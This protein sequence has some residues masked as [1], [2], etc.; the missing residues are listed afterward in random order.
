MEAAFL[1]AMFHDMGYP[2]QYISHL[3]NNL[4]L[5]GFQSDS[6]SSEAA[7]LVSTFGNRLLYSPL[8]GY[9]ALGRNV[10]ANFHQRLIDITDR[11]LR[12]THG[13][14]GAIGFL[15]LND[16][17][18]DYP[19]D[20]THPIRQFCVEW[21][22]MAI[23]MHDM[24]KIYWGDDTKALPDNSHMRLRFETDPLS[25]VVT[26]ADVL[27]DFSRPFA[28]FQKTGVDEG[29]GVCLAYEKGCVI[30]DL[31]LDWT[32]PGTMKITYLFS[33]RGKLAAKLSRIDDEQTMYFDPHRGYID[34]S[35]IGIAKVEM[36][37]RMMP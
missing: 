9:R 33:D 11:A 14:P 2:W 5:A 25:C 6:P 32:P 37:A 4:E 1:A 18:R 20:G 34:L 22:A 12:K 8:N 23:M 7:K 19:C 24:A 29:N 3:T 26:L 16:V 36:Q 17:L 13:F 27:Q 31:E 35:A 21:A 30:T 15:Y 28:V 10:P